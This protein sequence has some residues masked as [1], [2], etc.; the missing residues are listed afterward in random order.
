[1]SSIQPQ[2]RK[3]MCVKSNA[4]EIVNQTGRGKAVSASGRRKYKE[5][6]SQQ[7]RSFY[8]SARLG[9]FSEA[10]RHLGL[11]HPTVWE[12]VRALEGHLGKALFESRGR[13]LHLTGE[14]K[15]FFELASPLVLGMASLPERFEEATSDHDVRLA[16]A[17]TPRIVAEDL[18]ECIKSF[19]DHYP[20]VRFS[21]HEV[22]DEHVTE[23]VSSGEVDLG[24]TGGRATAAA[25]P[26][27]HSPWLASET[28]YELD[29]ALVTPK[30]HP[31]ARRRSIRLE[32]LR[33]YPLV[34]A[35][36]AFPDPAVMAVLDKADVLLD[37]Q[38]RINAFFAATICRYV[39]L[40][41]GIGLV[42]AQ[43]HRK[44]RPNLCQRVMTGYF[45]KVK[46]YAWRRRGAPFD[47][48]A[49]A[50]LATVRSALSPTGGG[51]R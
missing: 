48:S 32:D 7:L 8:E 29:V 27:G 2:S 45:G 37:H 44:P 23:M 36:D 5:L 41:F 14:G 47:S 38:H 15:T 34:N 35:L 30:E 17:S 3:G 11:A 49:D 43:P 9:S 16:V 6:T 18:P 20:R 22:G 19:C 1:M 26:W 42:V 33:A 28:V 31:L 40:G 4:N 46:I 39:E 10:A 25:G 13:R 50:F 21:I 51:S 12:Q 24:L